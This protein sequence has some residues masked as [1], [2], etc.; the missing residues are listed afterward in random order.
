[1]RGGSW[2]DTP[3]SCHSEFRYQFTPVSRYFS[4]GFRVMLPAPPSS[5]P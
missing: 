1:L 5:N 4:I 3:E 2:N